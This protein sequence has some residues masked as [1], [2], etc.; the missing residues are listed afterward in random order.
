VSV[1]PYIS[2]AIKSTSS[3]RFVATSQDNEFHNFEHAAHVLMSVLKL[4][5]RMTSNEGQSGSTEYPI[6]FDPLIQFGCVLAALVH[7]IDHQGVSNM[8]LVSEQATLATLYNNKAVAEQNS[9]D[10]AWAVFMADE[11]TDFRGAVC[12]TDHHLQ[13]LRQVVVNCVIATDIVDKDLKDDRNTRWE[14]GFMSGNSLSDDS[15]QVQNRRATLVL[16]HLIQASDISHC[17]QH[18]QVYRKWNERLFREMYHAYNIGRGDRNP[19]EVW[20]QG[21]LDFFDFYII[22]LAKKLRDCHVFGVSS[23]EFLNYAEQNRKEWE[24]RG[25]EIVRQMVNTI[26]PRSV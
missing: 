9:I 15:Q 16:E 21:E 14:K 8:Q 6:H 10:I 2:L 25:E 13:R 18:W 5:G 11:Y 24:R 20:Y 12:P 17:M 3:H 22:P 4:L 23:D 26:H 7:D 1:H 19:A